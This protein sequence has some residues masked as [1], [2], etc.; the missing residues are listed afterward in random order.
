[1]TRDSTFW[2]VERARRAG[3]CCGV[4]EKM[5]GGRRDFFEGDAQTREGGSGRG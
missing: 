3:V 4:F 5:M 2:E 1:M